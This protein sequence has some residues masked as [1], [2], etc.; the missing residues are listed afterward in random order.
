MFYT[1][2]ERKRLYEALDFLNSEFESLKQRIDLMEEEKKFPYGI[3][4]D[5]TPKLKPG[6]PIKNKR[7]DW[8]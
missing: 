7:E 3:K 4:K 2:K 8:E 1:N 6:R 5:G